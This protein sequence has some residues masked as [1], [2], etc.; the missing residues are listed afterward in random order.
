MRQLCKIII[1]AIAAIVIC[2]GIGISVQARDSDGDIVI[3]VD[4][5]HGGNDGGAVSSYDNEADLNWNIAMAL[6]AELETY[7]GVKVYLTRGSAEWNSN[8][9][10]GRMGAQLGADL[11]VSVHNNSGSNSSANGVQVYGTVNSNYKASMQTLCTNIAAHVSALGLA[12][13]GYQTRVSTNDPSI[14]YYTML[15]EAV[16]CG[17]PG[18]I[19]EHCYLSNTSD[20]DFIHNEDNQRKCGTADATAIAEYYGLTKRGVSAGSEITLIRTYSAHM[21]GSLNGTYTSSDNSIAY[22]NENGLITAVGAGKAVITCTSS[23]GKKETVTVNVPQTQLIALAA[24]INPTFYNAGDVSSYN[25]STVMVKAIYTDGSAVQL[26]SGYTFGEISDSGNGAYDVPVY[27][28]GLS[29]S[30]RL[31]GTGAAGSYSVDNYKVIGSNKDVL[32]YP[33]IYNGINTGISIVADG[34]SYTGTAAEPVEPPT[35]TPTQ[36]PTQAPTEAMPEDPTEEPT[37][38]PTEEPTEMTTEEITEK[39]T[40]EPT[41]GETETETS[42]VQPEDSRKIPVGLIVAAAVVLA[43]GAAVAVIYGIRRKKGKQYE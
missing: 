18:I 22:V 41:D 16:K 23:D 21:I 24:G 26:S 20:A 27:Y 43:A 15:D 12:N 37:E 9:A 29:C 14:D 6:K 3:I 42:A 28:Q 40:E 5:G 8:A 31:Y 35:E 32:V 17:I 36:E 33:A 11:F 7:N 2:L 10:R 19:I 30:L 38:A 39:P 4:P 1:G 13:G 34:N 25:Q